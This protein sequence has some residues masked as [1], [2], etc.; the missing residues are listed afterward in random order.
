MNVGNKRTSPND[1][2][3]R[4]RNAKPKL[5][6]LGMRHGNTVTPEDLRNRD[7]ASFERNRREVASNGLPFT[8]TTHPHTHLWRKKQ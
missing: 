6:Y 4:V 3:V 2:L 1:E 7:V 8:D 5:F